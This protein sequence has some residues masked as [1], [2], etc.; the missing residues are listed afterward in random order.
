MWISSLVSLVL[1]K[2]VIILFSGVLQ[3]GCSLLYV[4]I[5][6]I[7]LYIV[8]TGCFFHSLTDTFFKAPRCINELSGWRQVQGA[9]SKLRHEVPQLAEV[10]LKFGEKNPSHPKN[11]QIL[12]SDGVKIYAAM[13]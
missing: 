3:D 12:R 13:T 9:I 5:F 11:D 1:L 4:H 8:S 6:L 7:C 10:R 2:G